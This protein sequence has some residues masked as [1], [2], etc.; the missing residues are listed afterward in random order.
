MRKRSKSRSKSPKK[1][2]EPTMPSM[3][4]LQNFLNKAPTKSSPAE[5]KYN[6]NMRQQQVPS[7][8]LPKIHKTTAEDYMAQS[9]KNDPDREYKAKLNKLSEDFQRQYEQLSSDRKQKPRKSTRFE[10][11]SESMI[12]ERNDSRYSQGSKM[13][14][15]GY[16]LA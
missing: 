15:G 1:K 5:E 13:S 11:D 3:D 10:D 12:R 4:S 2:N 6:D 7:K 14:H 8:E 16:D 9:A